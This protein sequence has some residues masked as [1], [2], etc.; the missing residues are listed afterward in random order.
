MKNESCQGKLKQV[1]TFAQTKPAFQCVRFGSVYF[2]TVSDVYWN[3]HIP[4]KK[5][6][7]HLHI[8]HHYNECLLE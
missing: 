4:V 1:S 7:L 8:N 6:T 2:L 3:C 5:K